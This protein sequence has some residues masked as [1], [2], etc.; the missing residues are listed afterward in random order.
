MPSCGLLFLNV[1][2]TQLYCLDVHLLRSKHDNL[3][4]YLEYVIKHE[5]LGIGHCPTNFTTSYNIY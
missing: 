5:K 3:Y 2:C 4:I 1:T